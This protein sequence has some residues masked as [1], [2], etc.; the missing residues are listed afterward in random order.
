MNEIAVIVTC[1]APYLRWL[2]E[3][4]ESIDRQLPPP[5]ECVLICDRCQPSA[6]ASHWQLVVGDWGDPAPVRNAGMVATHA[7]WMIF[8]DAD[9]V[10]PPGYIAAV[11]DAVSAAASDLAIV[12]PDI[13]YCNA[14]LEPQS[15][16]QMPTWDYWAMR[17]E[18]CIDTSSAWRREA[19]ELAGGWF[20]DVGLFEDYALALAITA[21]GWKAE[22]LNGPAML[23]RLHP[24]GRTQVSPQEVLTSLWR[25]RSLA[26]VSLLAGRDDTFDRWRNFLL[27]ADLPP[28]TALYVADNSGR[29]E[30]TRKALD[31]CHQINS[32][33]GLTHL[34]FSATGQPYRPSPAE[35]YLIRERHLHVARL[36]ANLLTRVGEDLVLTLEDDVE[37]PLDAVPR[38]AGEI[39]HRSRGAVGAVA[40]A[41][42]MPHMEGQVCAAQGRERWGEP[43]RWNQVPL[44]PFDVG[45]VG[46]GCTVWANWVLRGLP[47]HFWWDATL[48]WD[49]A[50]CIELQRRGYQVRLHGGVR[51]HHHV[52]G[53][54]TQP[55]SAD[56]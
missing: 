1:H 24:Q 20:S 2:P 53:R 51:C 40:A 19:V 30:F 9:N 3:A 29:K 16:W 38:L 52:H 22:R 45:F 10:M 32:A 23:M 17:A 15:V 8:W 27:K 12:Y 18:N 48:G 56:R 35:P 49:G 37:P 14:S 11:R 42:A 34:S 25:A 36:Y 31:A 44:K 41:Y 28:R 43:L 5:A 7:Q 6:I 46:G 33:R 54:V 26:I 4:L 39:G 55:R 47:I 50:L 21:L 13:Q